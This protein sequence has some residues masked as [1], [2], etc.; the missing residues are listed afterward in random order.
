M[1]VLSRFPSRQQ[2]VVADKTVNAAM[3]VTVATVETDRVIRT[4]KTKL[5]VPLYLCNSFT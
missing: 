1:G 5:T 4:L 3:T 2:S